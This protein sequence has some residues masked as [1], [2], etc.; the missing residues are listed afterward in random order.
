[1]FV[2]D[3]DYQPA[4]GAEL[5]TD[6]FA[7]AQSIGRNHNLLVHAGTVT[8]NRH[9]RRTFGLAPGANRLANDEAKAIET[10]MFPARHHIAFDTG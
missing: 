9:L 8:V 6:L 2:H 3:P 1:V 4:H 10:R 7:G 5:V